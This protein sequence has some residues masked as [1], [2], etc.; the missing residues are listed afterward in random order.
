MNEKASFFQELK[1][2]IR[3]K[4]AQQYVA[5][6]LDQHIE[7]TTR[8]LMNQ[9]VSREEAE[10]EAVEQMGDP[11]KLGVEMNKLHKPKVEWGLVAFFVIAAGLGF[12][13]LMLL[14]DMEGFIERKAFYV[15]L[16]MILMTACMFFDYRKLQKYGWWFYGLGTFILYFVFV[17]GWPYE[18]FSVTINGAVYLV[19]G[20]ISTDSTSILPF[21]F[22]AWASFLNRSMSK[23]KLIVLFALPLILFSQA[24][25][26]ANAMMY[27]A[28]VVVMYGWSI[29]RNR[30]S[31]GALVLITPFVAVGSL[32]AF[33]SIMNEYQLGR[34]RA[35]L[36]PEEHVDSGGYIP[37]LIKKFITEASWFP[38]S[39]PTDNSFVPEAHTDMVLVT[40]TYGLGWGFLCFLLVVLI[41]FAARMLWMTGKIKDPFGQ[42]LIIGG[43]MLYVA[44]LLYNLLMI[45]GWLPVTGV[46]VPFIS[47]GTI[48]VWLYAFVIGIMLS[49]FRRK[50]F[51]V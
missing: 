51:A 17:Q 26:G 34:W 7:S 29:R 16:G 43:L 32:L 3:S 14:R 19:L 39:I 50:S 48:V 46:F 49:V 38:Q 18:P 13:P 41:G 8:T 1:S 31:L 10:K 45:A 11:M 36:H 27:T 30:K 44:P 33:L 21:Y 28:M 2:H 37:L 40:L 35:F 20:P 12:L 9:G 4:E 23:W 5:L 47:Y 25:S 15:L 24:A 22:F 6:E 42:L